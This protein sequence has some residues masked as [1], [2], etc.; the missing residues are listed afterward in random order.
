[1]FS[2]P[3][4]GAFSSMD[5]AGDASTPVAATVGHGEASEL[6][7]LQRVVLEKHEA[8][9][10]PGAAERRSYLDVVLVNLAHLSVLLFRVSY[11]LGRKSLESGEISLSEGN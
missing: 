10:V 7:S 4:Q 1:M 5:S 6:S 9:G 3:E 8:S 2:A 11:S